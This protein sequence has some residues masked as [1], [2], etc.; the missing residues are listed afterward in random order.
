MILDSAVVHARRSVG[1]K[2]IDLWVKKVLGMFRIPLSQLLSYR[3]GES[4]KNVIEIAFVQFYDIVSLYDDIDKVLGCVKLVW[5]KGM[6]ENEEE[7]SSNA[8][9]L[10]SL[11][12]IPCI[13]GVVH[14]IRDDYAFK[15]RCAVRSMDEVPWP[16][17]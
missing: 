16:V 1:S 11:L 6:E 2:K 5:G 7:D 12:P 4:A 3:A 14:V 17:V 9:K 10:Y 13:R 8:R 15:G